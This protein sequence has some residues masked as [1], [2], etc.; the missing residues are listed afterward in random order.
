MWMVLVLTMAVLR[1]G[2]VLAEEIYRTVDENGRAHYT[3]G[4]A[5][6]E[7]DDMA[8]GEAAAATPPPAEQTEGSAPA[9]PADDAF[10][11]QASLRRNVLERDLRATEKQLRAVDERIA[12]FAR[13]RM[14]N[15]RGS[16]ATGGI[17]GFAADV[18][19]EE[20]KALTLQRRELAQHA[21]EIRA[22][23]TQLRNEVTARRGTTP[24]WW[25]DVR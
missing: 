7:A 20:E 15:A 11:T 8:T 23:A 22:A 13:A 5:A 25:V 12:L 3:N 10:S 14:Q 1:P 17:A 9:E 2:T 6:G 19:S 4:P 21:N 18:R 24:E 16:A